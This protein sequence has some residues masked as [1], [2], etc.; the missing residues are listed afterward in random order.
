MAGGRLLLVDDSPTVRKLVDLTFAKSSWFTE[1]ATTGADA[2][3]AI[4]T[5]APDVIVLDY[6]LPDMRGVDVCER[7]ARNP[8]WRS[9]PFVVMS[10]KGPSIA[11]L[12]RAFEGFQE[13][14]P[15][16]SSS[17]QIREAVERAHAAR[18][19]APHSAEH[20]VARESREALAKA[21][22]TVLREGLAQIPHYVRELGDAAPAPF[23]ARRLLTAE[24]VGRLLTSFGGGSPR[25]HAALPAAAAEAETA[26]LQGTLRGWPVAGL[27]TFLEASARSGELVL[28]IGGQETLAYLRAGEVLMVTTREPT[29]YLRGSLPNAARLGIVPRE[30]LRAAEDEQ[31]SSGTPLFV[32]LAAAG[33][34]PPRELTEVLRALGRKLLLAAIDAP[35]LRFRFRDLANLPAY[36]EAHG[37]HV[38]FA[39]NTLAHEFEAGRG[40]GA[41]SALELA[42]VRLRES[43]PRTLP[44][45]A[46]VFTRA[47]GFSARVAAFELTAGERR[48]LAAVDGVA[49]A[50]QLALRLG[51]AVAELC[52]TLG[53]MAEIGLLRPL[54]TAAAKSGARTLMILE[55][56]V[57]DFQAPLAS[58]LERRAEPVRLVDLGRE[59]DRVGA[60]VRER[61]CAVMLNA[62][63]G[64]SRELL[65]K[66]RQLSEVS[67][68]PLVALVEPA[69]SG[70]VER[71][72]QA[73][74]D[75]AL[76]K[77]VAFSDVERLLG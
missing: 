17:E 1:C 47:H 14:I 4:A 20:A 26:S 12:F 9:I 75:A 50:E 29:Q 15:K 73:G 24:V 66:L 36:V 71:L 62:A 51:T 3:A 77:P 49:S 54:T 38:S 27:V 56:D 69:M 18:K 21:I 19:P 35:A 41:S 52:A 65:Q 60:V 30:A 33:H 63:S 45:P 61:P 34:F 13:C 67:S 40:P 39:R 6:M 11:P 23:F 2:L 31:R 55:E 10:A 42:L 8:A 58:L 74:F 44:Q 43:G 48:V 5:S 32:T 59:N 68:I 76:V 37:R 46:Q 22:Y 25:S 72:L 7:L 28:E 53:C 16:P 64:A 70:E 57:E